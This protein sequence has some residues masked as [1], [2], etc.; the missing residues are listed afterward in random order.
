MEPKGACAR[1]RRK[2]QVIEPSLVNGPCADRRRSILQSE[3]LAPNT[4]IDHRLRRRLVFDSRQRTYRGVSAL[5]GQC[6]YRVPR[7]WY[8]HR[9]TFQ[10]AQFCNVSPE[11]TV[12]FAATD[13][14][15]AVRIE[16]IIHN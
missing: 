3:A 5:R 16:G 10:R 6:V 2:G 14:R 12:R 7:C 8:E 13:H 11:L 4:T 1:S 9:S 15:L